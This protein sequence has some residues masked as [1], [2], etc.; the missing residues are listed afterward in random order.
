MPPIHCIA[1]QK[2]R[3]MLLSYRFQY[4]KPTATLALAIRWRGLARVAAY[5][6]KE[7]KQHGPKI[8]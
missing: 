1:V 8:H 2:H 4:V 6:V 7:P 5:L 3:R